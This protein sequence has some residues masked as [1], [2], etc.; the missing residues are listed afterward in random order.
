[1]TPRTVL[2]ISNIQKLNGVQIGEENSHDIRNCALN[3]NN[4]SNYHR[5][6]QTSTVDQKQQLRNT[7]RND[8][9]KPSRRI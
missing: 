2:L 6:Y 9:K 5:V 4:K 3:M 7:Y 8:T 1:M